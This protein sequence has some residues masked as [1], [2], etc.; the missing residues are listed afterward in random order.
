[1]SDKAKRSHRATYA[2]DKIHGGYIVRVEGPHANRFA[3]RTVPITRRD[4]T[5]NEATL[6]K[7]LWT[8]KDDESGQPVALYSF[9]PEQKKLNDE[10]PF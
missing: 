3:G 1:M 8:G 9:A 2:T 5:E 7:L 6:E 4:G 10:I